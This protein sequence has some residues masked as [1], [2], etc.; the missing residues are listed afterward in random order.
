MGEE[1]DTEVAFELLAQLTR[2]SS[3]LTTLGKEQYLL[4]P[5]G[6][7]ERGMAQRKRSR[8]SAR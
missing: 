1:H 2:N 4:G 8:H 5:F 7:M 3:S 6:N